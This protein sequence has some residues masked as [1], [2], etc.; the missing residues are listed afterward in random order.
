M[1]RFFFY[2]NCDAGFDPRL[3]LSVFVCI[4]NWIY[5][6]VPEFA[7]SRSSQRHS[8]CDKCIF[9]SS[10]SAFNSFHVQFISLPF[11][12]F[13]IKR[14]VADS[15]EVFKFFLLYRLSRSRRFH[16]HWLSFT[17][18]HTQSTFTFNS[19][20]KSRARSRSRTRIIAECCIV[21]HEQAAWTIANEISDRKRISGLFMFFKQK[22]FFQFF[23]IS[24]FFS[25]FSFPE[26]YRRQILH[27]HKT[28]ARPTLLF[29]RL[30]IC[31]F[32]IKLSP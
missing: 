28:V 4:I 30:A 17:H 21:N 18:I 24:P 23:R 22:Q 20:F 14:E 9:F 31:F 3:L 10:N 11:T 25:V 13:T 1:F 26:N 15:C 19:F 2:W 8:L 29:H 32:Q 5:E 12:E 7:D 6:F 27:Y 16:C